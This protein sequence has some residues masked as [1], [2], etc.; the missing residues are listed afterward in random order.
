MVTVATT[1]MYVILLPGIIL[2][3]PPEENQVFRAEKG[4]GK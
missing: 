4:S 1:F 3:V 2:I